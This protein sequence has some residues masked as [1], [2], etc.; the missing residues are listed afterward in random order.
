V[1]VAREIG[2]LALVTAV[3]AGAELWIVR[4]RRPD[5]V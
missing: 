2:A 5:L 1:F 3:A 4:S